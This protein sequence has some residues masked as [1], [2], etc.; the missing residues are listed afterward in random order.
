L[1]AQYFLWDRNKDSVEPSADEWRDHSKACIEDAARADVL[2]LVAFED[3]RQFG[4]L[5][6]TGSAL[7]NGRQVFV[8]SPHPWPFLKH[9]PRVRAF[10]TIEGAIECLLA[11]ATGQRLRGNGHDLRAIEAENT[12]PF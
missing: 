7:G 10:N 3:E 9:H 4:A 12:V 11:M 2:V 5:L 6:E 1:P 8:I